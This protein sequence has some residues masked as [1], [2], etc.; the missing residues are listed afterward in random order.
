MTKDI[1]NLN[2]NLNQ[3]LNKD[4]KNYPGGEDV[5][6]ILEKPFL[7][8]INGKLLDSGDHFNVLNPAD[9]K[10]IAQ[11]PIA[12][13]DQ[14]EQAVSAAKLA[15]K[16]WRLDS[17]YR[18]SCIRLCVDRLT[19]NI[20]QIALLLTLEQGKPLPQALGEVKSAIAKINS[21]LEQEVPV[22]TFETKEK[23]TFVFRHPIGVV[24]GIA[25]WNYPVSIGVAKMFRPISIGNTVV[26]KPA[27]VTP[28]STLYIAELISDILPPGVLNVITGPGRLGE[29]LVAHPD[30]RM[31]TFTG[32]VPVGK[33]IAEVAAR[34]LTRVSLELGGNDASIVL[35]DTDLDKYAED[36]FW[37][38]FR[39]SGQ[40]C[41]A[42]KRLY[43]QEEIYEDLLNRLV[44]MANSVKIGNGLDNT[45]SM[46]PINNLSQLELVEELVA[47]A[48]S[49]G[50]E[51]LC[52]GNRLPG[53]GYFY[54]PTIISNISEGVRLVDEEQFGPV[55]PAMKF[56]DI[57][58]V[59]SRVNRSRLGLAGSVWC[60]DIKQGQE[61]AKQIESGMVWVNH[62]LGSHPKAPFGGMKES[63]VGREGGNWGPELMSE[64]QA[65]TILNDG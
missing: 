45:N 59:I 16:T 22:D 36:I 41:I 13:A 34:D 43:I 30:V 54:P 50:G 15:F 26:M 37:G 12:E 61:I 35:A 38:A 19:A 39:N 46:G 33:R 64:L 4:L 53:D 6:K 52:G 11:A 55:L 31:V 9:N 63:G 56:K 14:V 20:D 21:S 29:S 47:D 32:S 57:D 48:K 17:K 27:S 40:I 5:L 58:E 2:Q 24:A 60:G 65:V 1:K 7:N 42:S 3:N 18:K 62:I 49:H 51:V 8:L 28:L 10:I 25:P 44:K 23:T